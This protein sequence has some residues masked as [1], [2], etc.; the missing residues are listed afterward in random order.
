MRSKKAIA[1]LMAPVLGAMALTA[2]SSGADAT[3]DDAAV[4]LDQDW[5]KAEPIT[6]D[7][8]D[9]L[10]NY[11]GIQ[12]G[13]F[14]KIVKD[15][16][17]MELNIIAPNVAG[18]GDTLYNTRVA[19]G[20][21]GDLIVTDKGEKMDELIAG[22]LLLETSKYYDAMTS[23]PKYDK[24]VQRLN[25]GENGI[26]GFPTQVSEHQ[27][28][29]PS[30]GLDPT[31]G[32]YLRWDYYAE[33]GY[34]EIDTLEDLLPVLK[35][36]Q[37]AHPTGDDGKPTY[38]FSLFKDWDGNMMVMAKQPA[39]L[40]GF[41]E[42]GFVLAMADGSEYQ[43]ILDSDSAYV[44]SLNLYFQAN[45]MGLVD[46][47]STTQN[48]DTMFAKYQ[49]GG[50]LSSWWP[51]LGQ[52]A[53]NTTD[54]LAAGKG[55]ELVPMKDQKIFSYGAEVYGGKQIFAIGSKAE[56]PAR[57]AAFVDWLYSREGILSSGSQTMGPAGPEG[58]TWELDGDA[59][60]LTDFGKAAILGG[61]GDV[62]ADWGGGKYADGVSALN[63]TTVLPIDID[64]KT[65]LP[66]NYK[67]WPSVQEITGNPLTDDWSEHMGGATSTMEYL[68][69]NDQVLVGPGAGFAAAP[70]TS[71]V[72]T[73]RNQVKATIVEYSWKMVFAKDKAEFDALLKELQTTA[74][75]L[76]YQKVLD[77]DMTNAKA[78]NDARLAA[79]E[80]FE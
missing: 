75:G 29:E 8:F 34:P 70:D 51:W 32:P 60:V 53:Y 48:Y 67:Y 52:S 4:S 2:C 49:K 41:D 73:I 38:G 3:D 21:L 20:E 26:Y 17:N 44:R 54:N 6:I 62:P 1:L 71:E 14:A 25:D 79:V 45:Q 37:T 30:E 13:W 72:E 42:M 39:C 58:L 7:V 74:D 27:P 19:G 24:A 5:S 10:A 47:E 40:Y 33:L 69:D 35:D 28:S 63:V 16:F 68:Q 76:G 50:V 77:F 9:G 56:D 43:S 57:I 61:D 65:G 64:E 36:M 80:A 23:L 78:Q 18:G 46:P 11:H 55:F 12:S 59:P 66:Y 15:K 22:G 31:F